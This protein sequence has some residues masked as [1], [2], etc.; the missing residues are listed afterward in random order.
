MGLSLLRIR[1]GGEHQQIQKMKIQFFLVATLQQ[2]SLT[3]DDKAILSFET[4]LIS[5]ANQKT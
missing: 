5:V 1:S 3:L 2:D 4:S